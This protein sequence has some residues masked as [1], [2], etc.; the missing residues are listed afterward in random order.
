VRLLRRKLG[1]NPQTGEYIQS[2]RGHG[3][4]LAAPDS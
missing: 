3:Y 4:M 2:V 1:L